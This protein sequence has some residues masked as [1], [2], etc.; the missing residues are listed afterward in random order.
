MIVG[1]NDAEP[2]RARRSDPKETAPLSNTAVAAQSS[3]EE[4]VVRRY[5]RAD[6]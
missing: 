3:D 6:L 4:P 2:G 5:L 1:K